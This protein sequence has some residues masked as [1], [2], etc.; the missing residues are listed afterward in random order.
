MLLLLRYHCREFDVF[1]SVVQ[2][3]MRVAFG[4]VMYVP[5]LYRNLLSVI[6]DLSAALRYEDYFGAGVV[7]MHA[8]GGSRNETSLHYAVRSVEK[9]LGAEFLLSALESRKYGLRN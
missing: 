3:R 4:T 5:C 1:V 9:H 7:R 6:Y 8:D 2:E